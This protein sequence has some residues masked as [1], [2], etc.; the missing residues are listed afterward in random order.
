V[1]TDRPISLNLGMPQQ[2]PFDARP[3]A[4][5]QPGADAR[6]AGQLSD[7]ARRMRDL[8][9]NGARGGAPASPPASTAA[10]AENLRPLDLFGGPASVAAQ[11]AAARGEAPQAAVPHDVAGAG[12]ALSQLASRLLVSDGSSGRR[13]VQIRLSDEGLAGVVLDVFE[14]GGRVVAQFVCTL[15]P[16][17][18]RLARAAGWLAAGL[19]ERLQRETLVRVLADDPEDPCPVESAGAPGTAGTAA[20]TGTAGTAGL[21]AA[22]PASGA[23]SLPGPWPRS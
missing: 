6:D 13:A 23:P 10:S 21:P 20:T 12:E 7:E 17:R 2:S 3:D 19:A 1:S 18:E 22:S 15:E 8:M 11:A 16:A 14:D 9:N 4:E 5:R